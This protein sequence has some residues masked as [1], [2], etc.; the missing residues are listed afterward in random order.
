MKK[1]WRGLLTGVLGIGMV[2]G[3]LGAASAASTPKDIQG[4]WA[5]SKVQDWLN[6]GYLTGY[7]DGTFKPNKVITRAE[8]VA[9]VNRLFSFKDTATVT[10]TDVKTTNWAYSEVAKA[11]KAGYINGYSNN[12]FH[13]NNPIT[14]QEAAVIAA[15]VLHLSTDATSTTF[16]DAAQISNWARGSV[17]AVANLKIITGYPN[18]TFGPKKPLTRAEA[19]IIVGNSSA[20]Y[21]GG[22]SATPTP[23]ATPAPSA[24]P[25][26][27]SSTGGGGTVVYPTV[28][29]ATYGHVGSVTADVY[30]TSNVTGSVYYVVAAGSAALP[31]VNEI[32][33]GSAGSGVTVVNK[34][35]KSTTAGS[36]V[37]FSVYGLTAGTNYSAFMILVDNSGN[38]SVSVARVD[39]KTAASTVTG[40]TYAAPGT[41]TTVTSV[42]YVTYGSAGN[43]SGQIRYVVIPSDPSITT[44]A[45]APNAVQVWNGQNAVGTAVGSGWRGALSS[46]TAGT[47]TPITITG[48]AS[49]KEY[50][51]YLVAGNGSGGYSPVEVVTVQTK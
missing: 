18:G 5:Q 36:T 21:T 35:L 10:F 42:V 15:K 34:G 20:H 32:Y 33:L 40:I 12:T 31:T 48:L 38:K 6:K 13:P 46:V 39:F 3:S 50:K 27:T 2:F 19:V 49:G 7:P 8:F 17:A 28:S 24:T 23:T 47:R 4:H 11:V 22:A 41:S 30:F 29:G 1:F 26:P 44:G 43:P 14:R 37:S 25:T 45:A 9:V 16:K 51:V